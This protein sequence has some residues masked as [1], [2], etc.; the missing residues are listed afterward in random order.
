MMFPSIKCFFHCN[1]NCWKKNLRVC[2]FLTLS[3]SLVSLNPI[4]SLSISLFPLSTNSQTVK[5]NY[6]CFYLSFFL[7]LSLLH[8]Y[9][10]THSLSLTHAHTISVFLS[11]YLSLTHT[12]THTHTQTNTFSLFLKYLAC[13]FALR[14]LYLL[15]L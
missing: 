13:Y 5:Q 9:I 6:F 14:L 12:N 2:H 15:L 7:S 3:L 11:S 1:H 8:T 4:F 10:H